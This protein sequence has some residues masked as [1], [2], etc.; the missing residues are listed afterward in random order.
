MYGDQ[1][2]RVQVKAPKLSRGAQVSSRGVQVPSRGA[3]VP[4]RGARVPSRT[5]QVP[6]RGYRDRTGAHPAV[7]IDEMPAAR[8]PKF[9]MKFFNKGLANMMLP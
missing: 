6:G 3:Q 2:P 8:R 1:G 5:T 4:S 9:E 7:R